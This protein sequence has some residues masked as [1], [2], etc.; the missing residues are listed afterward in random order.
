MV[1][2]FDRDGRLAAAPVS[3]RKAERLCRSGKAVR[4]ADNAIMLDRPFSGDAAKTGRQLRNLKSVCGPVVPVVDA[5]PESVRFAIFDYNQAQDDEPDPVA[6]LMSPAGAD[7]RVE[8]MQRAAK[9]RRQMARKEQRRKE[10]PAPVIEYRMSKAALRRW[11][12]KWWAT[13]KRRAPLAPSRGETAAALAAAGI[14][15]TREAVLKARMEIYARRIQPAKMP[16][17]A[18]I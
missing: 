9:R 14:R 11:R 12:R 18:P 2:V 3:S 15:P 17:L 1:L 13:V 5:L 16:R 8:Q 6:A 7:E 4:I 10:P